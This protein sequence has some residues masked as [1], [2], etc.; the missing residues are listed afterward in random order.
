MS[1]RILGL[2][3]EPFHALFDL[4]DTE[5]LVRGARRYRIEADTGFPCRISLEDAPV[6]ETVILTNHVHLAAPQSPYRA[7]GP[8]FV[9]E[10]PVPRFDAVDTVPRQLAKRLLSLRAYDGEAMMVEGLVAEGTALANHVEDL[11]ALPEVAFIHAH[12]A[13]RG[14][15]AARIERA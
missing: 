13:R 14:C 7:A 6:G 15:Y 4:T 11:F 10:R 2:D 1:F 12:F 9:R 8:I 3:P 5:L